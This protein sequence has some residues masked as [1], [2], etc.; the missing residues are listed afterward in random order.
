MFKFRVVDRKE[1]DNSKGI[2]YALTYEGHN[3]LKLRT[4]GETFIIYCQ[5]YKD[6]TPR[7][8]RRLKD[9]LD[10]D[11][12]LHPLKEDDDDGECI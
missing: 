1:E 8:I 7:M 2:R 11:E 9:F 10:L 6:M 3:L 5:G 4:P 12:Y